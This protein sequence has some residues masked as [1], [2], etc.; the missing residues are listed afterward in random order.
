[1]KYITGID[2]TNDRA[3]RILSKG[4]A[5]N[6]AEDILEDRVKGPIRGIFELYELVRKLS[7]PVGPR[8]HQLFTQMLAKLSE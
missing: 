3:L 6:S 4:L 1:M 2:V 8:L 7:I 5:K